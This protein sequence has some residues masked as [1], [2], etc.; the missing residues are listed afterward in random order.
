MSKAID[1]LLKLLKGPISFPCSISVT[2]SLALLCLKSNN[3]LIAKQLQIPS[4]E[5]LLNWVTPELVMLQ[6]IA[7]NMIMWDHVENSKAWIEAQIPAYMDRVVRAHSFSFTPSHEHIFHCYY[8][9]VSGLCFVI[10]LK[11]AS[12]CDQ[13]AFYGLLYFFQQVSQ[14][15]IS[16]CHMSLAAKFGY[17]QRLFSVIA[18]NCM[19]VIISSL[20]MVM[21]GSGNKSLFGALKEL[22]AQ[23]GPEITYGSHLCIS[24]SLGLLFLSKGMGSLGNSNKAIAAL[25]CS[26]F[27][28]YP[29]TSTD[30][31][32]H[33]QAL[34]HLWVLAYEERCLITRDVETGKAGCVPIEVVCK[35]G[36][37]L[38]D[39]SPLN[40]PHFSTIESLR[41]KGPRY[42]DIAL[43]LEQFSSSSEGPTREKTVWVQRKTKFLSYIQVFFSTYYSVGF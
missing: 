34:R 15:F 42:W 37:N 2:V 27:P 4:S 29:Q 31:R 3:A 36:S 43:P 35:D 13:G 23:S 21:A 5:F 38:N 1:R 20:A 8:S 6:T 39:Y 18:R 25:F 28:M 9:I 26:F 14:A 22:Q 40:L 19:N 10:G 24:M 16:S 30:N 7:K 11:F 17:S 12:T 32:C 33:L 41:V